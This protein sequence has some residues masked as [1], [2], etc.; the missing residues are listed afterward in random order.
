[1][2][3]ARNKNHKVDSTATDLLGETHY[4]LFSQYFVDNLKSQRVDLG[5]IRLF[6]ATATLNK[7]MLAFQINKDA[8]ENIDLRVQQSLKRL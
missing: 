6:R 8:F 1:M 2:N 5:H 3:I 4:C 7:P